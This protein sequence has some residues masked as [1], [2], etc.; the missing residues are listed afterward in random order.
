M[1]DHRQTI[2]K[3]EALTGVLWSSCQR[4][5]TEELHM[6]RV[7]AKFV[8]CLLSE[9][10]RANRLDVCREMKDQLKTDPDFLSKTITGDESWCYRYDPETKQQSSRWKSASSPRPKKA[11]QVKSNVKTMLICFFDIKGLVYFEFVPQGQTVN[12]QFYLEVL[13]RLLD[14][15]QRKYPELWR[16]GEQL[17]HHD[18]AP[19]H[20]ALSVHQFLAK[21]GM[22]TASHAPYSPD[23]APCDFFL[24]PIMKRDLKGKCFQTVE[25]VRAITLQEFQNCFEQWKKH[26]DKCIDSQGEYFE[27]DSILEIF[28]EL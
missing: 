11:R 18:S 2:D 20:T 9:D 6:K 13:K 16:S 4:I 28:R 27:G 8:P 24:F 19:A 25:E 12:Q 7:A 10:Q 1:F 5:L 22:A 21:N 14:A 26:W 23:L 17:L 3:L 15:V